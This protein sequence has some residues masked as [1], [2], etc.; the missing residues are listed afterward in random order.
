MVSPPDAGFEGNRDAKLRPLAGGRL[1]LQTAP[2]RVD[3]LPDSDQPESLRSS[4]GADAL[5]VEAGPVVPDRAA[6]RSLFAQE[7][8][9]DPG[10]VRVPAHVGQCLLDDAIEGRLDRGR[11][12]P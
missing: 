11:K 7:T 3:S 5:D 1:D 8:N 10:R 12:T 9:R 2:Q 4:A 6:D